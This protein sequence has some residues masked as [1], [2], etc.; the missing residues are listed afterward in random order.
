LYLTHPYSY[1]TSCIA[2]LFTYQ[3]LKFFVFSFLGFSGF[4]GLGGG[5]CVEVKEACG[6]LGVIV[7]DFGLCLMSCFCV[8][9]DFV[10]PRRFGNFPEVVRARFIFV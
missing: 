4:G 6:W 5:G 9:G 2:S 3:D 7:V 1:H 8:K 10:D